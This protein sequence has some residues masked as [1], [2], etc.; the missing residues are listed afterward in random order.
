VNIKQEGDK[1]IMEMTAK[2]AEQIRNAFRHA[3]NHWQYE[4]IKVGTQQAKD[5]MAN[6][7]RAYGKTH[8]EIADVIGY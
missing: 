2:E 8:N 7:A 3:G 5:A 4:A 1:V 6:I